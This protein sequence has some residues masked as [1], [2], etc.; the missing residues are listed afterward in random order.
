MKNV[1]LCTN[2]ARKAIIRIMKTISKLIGKIQWTYNHK[3]TTTKMVNTP[4]H[5]F[6]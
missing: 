5:H 3:D 6:K 2:Q 1:L 4:V